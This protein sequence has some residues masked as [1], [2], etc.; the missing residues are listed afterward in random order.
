MSWPGIEPM[1]IKFPGADTL[2]TELPGQVHPLCAHEDTVHA[3]AGF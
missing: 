1:N 2:P 3:R